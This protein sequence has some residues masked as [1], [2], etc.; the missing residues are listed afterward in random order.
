MDD[1]KQ[2]EIS[3]GRVQQTGRIKT[4]KEKVISHK[5]LKISNIEAKV[6]EKDTGAI[7]VSNQTIF[8]FMVLLKESFV[9][10]SAIIKNIPYVNG[11]YAGKNMA[12]CLSFEN[13]SDFTIM[14]HIFY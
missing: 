1:T 2:L 4:W 5:I 6:W 7:R 9:S 13:G 11:P 8:H 10:L 12:V 3:N 14:S